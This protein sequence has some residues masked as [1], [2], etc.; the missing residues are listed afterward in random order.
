M[1]SVLRGVAV[2]FSIV[3]GLTIGMAARAQQPEPQKPATTES[4]CEQQAGA[5]S[6]ALKRCLRKLKRTGR[7]HRRVIGTR[8]T[9]TPAAQQINSAALRPVLRQIRQRQRHG[10]YVGGTAGASHHSTDR[11]CTRAFSI[12]L[13]DVCSQ[14]PIHSSG[15]SFAGGVVV[16]FNLPPLPFPL[17][18]TP[19]VEFGAIFPSGSTTSSGTPVTNLGPVPTADTYDIRD[20]SIL[21]VTGTVSF[22]LFANVDGFIQAGG[23]RIEKDITY[24]C[25][26]PGGFCGIAPAAT[27]FSQTQTLHLSGAVVGGGVEIGL[28]PIQGLPP[29]TFRLSHTAIFTNDKTVSFGTDATRSVQYNVGQ[30]LHLTQAA[31]IIPLGL[32]PPPPSPPPPPP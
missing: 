18:I 11:S 1:K 20:R 15:T 6:R 25:V 12:N 24:N 10:I 4:A 28:P 22:P 19:G 8:H 23:A 14:S 7:R 5:D 3:A 13:A 21:M 17:P 29:A 16:G 2:A 32:G 26:G 31:I 30:D 9:A 27:P